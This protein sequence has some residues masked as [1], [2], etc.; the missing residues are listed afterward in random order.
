[1]LVLVTWPVYDS[2]SVDET[3]LNGVAHSIHKPNLSC[4]NGKCFWTFK[5]LHVQLLWAICLKFFRK[6]CVTLQNISL[7]LS[8]FFLSPS[9]GLC[10]LAW[11]HPSH[12]EIFLLYIVLKT[13]SFLELKCSSFAQILKMLFEDSITYIL[14]AGFW[15]QIEPIMFIS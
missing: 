15:L 8:F 4:R 2:Q 5:N 10:L 9:I 14:T 13:M 12:G 7:S 6:C 1:M 3:W 11:E